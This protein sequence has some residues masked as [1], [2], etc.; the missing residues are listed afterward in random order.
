MQA[1]VVGQ[2]AWLRPGE[3]AALVCLVLTVYGAWLR[4]SQHPDP[5]DDLRQSVHR[6]AGSEPLECGRHL[7]IQQERR[8]VAADEAALQK[9][10]ECGV[11]A[12]SAKR[13]FWTFKQDQGIDSWV[14]SGILGTS[15]GIIYRYTYDSA[16]CGGPGCP[17]R[18]SFERCDNPVA[19]TGSYQRSEFRCVR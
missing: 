5:V 8:W 2:R 16:P 3:A 15:D 14:A 19:A 1:G 18:I 7:L 12:A 9:S 4:A 11:S 17:S 6:F 13:A 10:V